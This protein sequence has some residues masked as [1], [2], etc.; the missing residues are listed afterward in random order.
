MIRH[1]VM[2][3]LKSEAEGAT[4]REN[5]SRMKTMLD[6]CAGR[7][8]G[9]RRLEVGID[10]G[11][12]ATAWDVVLDSEFDDRAALDAYQEEPEH[13]KA[14]AFIAKIRDLRAAVD[15]ES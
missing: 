11:L 15:F 13:Q 3:K 7:T 8:T 6:A 1:I 14:K 9:M 4:K 12:D 5:A 10:V 2:W